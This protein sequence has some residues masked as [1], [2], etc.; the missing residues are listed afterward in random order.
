[1]DLVAQNGHPG[2]VG[3]APDG[4]DDAEA[5]PRL[6][7]GEHPSIA[8]RPDLSRK[9]ERAERKAGARGGVRCCAICRLANT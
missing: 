5:L 9:N 4:P 7:T 8:Q 6:R 3:V 2:A 1:M